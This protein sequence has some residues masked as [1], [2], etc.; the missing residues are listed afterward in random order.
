MYFGAIGALLTL[1]LALVLTIA[2]ELSASIPVLILLAL[3]ALLPASSLAIG[4]VNYLVTVLLPPRVLPKMDFKEG[5]PAEFATCVVIPTLLTNPESAA[6]LLERLEI[7][8]LA[9]ADPHLCFALLTDFGDAPSEHLPTDQACVQAALEG[10]RKLN[11]EY[12]A[13]G[14]E[15]FFLFHRCRAWNELSG[16]WM[17]WERKRGKLVEFN[18]LLRGQADKGI[19]VRSG[20]LPFPIRFVITLDTDTQLPRESAVRLVG[21]LAHPLNQP[22]LDPVQG[23]VVEG[24]GIL[25]PRVNITMPAAARSLFARLYSTSAGIDPYTTAVSDVYQDLFGTG[26][27]TGK[28]IYDVDAFESAVGERFP[29]NTIL[30]HDLIEG[31]FARCGLVS[32][33]QLLDDFPARYNVFARR[34]HRWTRGDWQ[35]L[36]WLFGSSP[37]ATGGSPVSCAPESSQASRL[38]LRGNPLPFL[39]RWKIFDNLR[40]SLVPA[41]LL[42]LLLLGWTVLPGSAWLWTGVALLV[43]AWPLVLLSVD[44]LRV[45]LH[46]RPVLET[47]REWQ[48]E[49]PSTLGQALLSVV[50]LVDQARLFVDAAVRTL[51]RLF[52]SRRQLLEWE[53]AASTELRL[54]YGIAGYA[55]I[56]WPTLLLTLAGVGLVLLVRPAALPAAAPLL[57]AWLASPLVAFWVSRPRPAPR[58]ALEPQD[59]LELRL[60]ARKIWSFFETFVGEQDHY[61]PPDNYQEDP[62]G[63]VAHRTSPTNMGLY[64]LSNLAALD[65][66]YLSLQKLLDRLEKTFDTLEKLERHHGHFHNWY[67]TLT[68]RSLQPIYLSTVDSGNLLGC[69]VTLK[70]GLLEI[71]EQD[72]LG[73]VRAGLADPLRLAGQALDRLTPAE[74][75]SVGAKAERNPGQRSAFRVLRADLHNLEQILG[76]QPA[77]L[78]EWTQFLSRLEEQSTALLGHVRELT[79]DLGET[80]ELLRWVQCFADQVREQRA[81]LAARVSEDNARASSPTTAE[82]RERLAARAAKLAADMDFSLLYNKQR[83][84]FAVGYN[85]TLGRLDNAHYDLLASESCLTSF[86]VIARGE[87]PR[88]HWFQLGRPLTR[89]AGQIALLSWGGTMFEYL[90][91]QL[92]LTALPNTLLEDSIRAAVDRQIQYGRQRHVPWGISESGYST[93]DIALDY[94]YQSFGVPGLGLRRGLDQDLVIAPYATLLALKVRPQAA[95]RNL[96]RLAEENAVGPYGCYEAI[97]YTPSRLPS[98][99]RSVVVRSYMAHHQG[100]SLVV[101]ANVLLDGPMPRRFHAEPMVRA[102]ELLLQERLPRTAPLLEISAGEAPVVTAPQEA[103]L[104]LSRSLNTPHTPHP[105]THLLSNGTYTVMVTNAGGSWSFFRPNDSSTSGIALDVTRW[106]ED[107]T[108]DHWGQFCYVRDLRG[109]RLWSPGHQPLCVPADTYEVLFSP[110]K[111]EFRRVDGLIETHVEVTVSPEHNCEVRRITLSNHDSRAHDL[112]LTSYAEPVLAPHAADLAHPAFGKLFLETEFL[113]APRRCCADAGRAPRKTNRSGA[114]TYWW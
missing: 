63:K 111:A 97:D 62:E 91:P 50:F 45:L 40:R 66:G 55:R 23:R 69:L 107:C 17:G 103:A 44:R 8:Y 96:R 87:A 28:G 29:D 15:R 90:M 51:Y 67:D 77:N 22:R 68:L 24:Y 35:I 61:L 39:E 106:R 92:L 100:M 93:L 38:W 42:F 114:C 71:R 26:S 84:L 48:A 12:C 104:R 101:L 109:G 64:L 1:F 10:I 57:L 105:R 46:G 98:N 41:A 74:R 99:C 54:G 52:V 20:E 108:R 30:S 110:D 75:R 31:N 85:L 86:L 60:L 81:E 43:P 112:E 14:S 73:A 72:L 4:L 9:N 13:G 59:R 18:R 47:F 88:R 34:E 58:T 70:Q 53:T 83:H 32:D 33:I 2:A 11:G 78:T 80:P 25:Q 27:F 5:I 113:P 94:Q 37:V 3:A 6:H 65:F 82:R 21:T 102:T 16:C 7:H 79:A 56:M 95:V 19:T 89:V 76:E 49:L 36:P